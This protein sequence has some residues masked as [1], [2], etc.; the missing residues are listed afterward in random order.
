MTR[1]QVDAALEDLAALEAHRIV[2]VDGAYR[3]DVSDV[4]EAAGLEIAPLA[5]T[6]AKSGDRAGEGLIR[7]TAPGQE[8]VVALNTA[9]MTDGAVVRIAKGTRLRKPILLVFI[10]AGSTLLT[11]RNVVRIGDKGRTSGAAS[12][13]RRPSSAASPSPTP[14]S[15]RPGSRGSRSPS[16]A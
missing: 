12:P 14:R 6:L 5:A 11:T 7:S 1:E 9:F 10:R 8:A 16:G 2:F 13:R 15:A 4:G 3:A